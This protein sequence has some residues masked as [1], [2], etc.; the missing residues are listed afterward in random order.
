MI[1][2]REVSEGDLFAAIKG[3]RVDGHSFAP[4][5]LQAGAAALLTERK[6]DGLV[7]QLVVRDITSA[8]GRFGHLKRCAFE[9]AVVAI[10]GSA[11]KTTT[12]NLLAAALAPVGAVHATTG[13]QNNE[14]RTDDAMGLSTAHQFGV[15]EMGAG[16]PGDINLLM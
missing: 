1:D 14:L 12:K 8:S 2:S 4:K 13:N 11:G 3:T 15:I 9:G 16:S 5:A 6:L 10:T 7:P